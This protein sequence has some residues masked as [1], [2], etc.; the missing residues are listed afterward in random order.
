MRTE[1][2][3]DIWPSGTGY[4]WETA[5][6]LHPD[7]GRTSMYYTSGWSHTYIGAKA[8]IWLAARSWE[9]L[10]KKESAQ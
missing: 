4:S 6:Y 8:G 9:R 10:I 3:Y 2:T 1:Q 7:Y 5:V